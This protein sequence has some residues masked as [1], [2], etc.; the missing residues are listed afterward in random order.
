MDEG[1]DLKNNVMTIATKNPKVIRDKNI[2]ASD[3]LA[4]VE[5]YKIQLLIVLNEDEMLEG[6]LHIHD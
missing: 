2:L 6:V 1:F 3:A 5:E 4:I